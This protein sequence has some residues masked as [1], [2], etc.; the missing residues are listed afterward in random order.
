MPTLSM[1]TLHFPSTLS[2]PSNLPSLPSGLPSIPTEFPSL[3]S[4]LPSLP[5]MFPSLPSKLPSL[6]T[7]LPPWPSSLPSFAELQESLPSKIPS[8]SAVLESARSLPPKTIAVY[9]VGAFVAY[10]FWLA[11]YRLFLSPLAKFPGRKL[12]ALTGW[13]EFYYDVIQTGMYW[14]QV[15][16]MH[17]EYG[18]II[19]ISPWEIHINDPSAWEPLY[20]AKNDKYDFG[21]RAIG[22]PDS[23]VGTVAHG[24]HRRRRAALS[25]FFSRRGVER[26][27]HVIYSAFDAFAARLEDARAVRAE[28]VAR[29]GRGGQDTI[30]AVRQLSAEDEARAGV[31]DMGGLWHQLAVDIVTEYAF[32]RGYGLVANRERGDRW[33]EMLRVVLR[34]AKTLQH[35]PL[36]L[37]VKDAVA[38]L[39]PRW[40]RALFGD[41]LA[42]V[43]AFQDDMRA[44]IGAI[45]RGAPDAGDAIRYK[46]HPTIFHDLLRS[47]SI[48]P[49]EKRLER[50]WQDG[51]SVVIGGSETVATV[52]KHITFHLL[53]RPAAL[54]RLRREL[55]E[56]GFMTAAMRAAGERPRWQDLERCRYLRGV[57]ME[58]LRMSLP[59]VQRM[60]RVLPRQERVFVLP[61]RGRRRRPGRNGAGAAVTA[62]EKLVMKEWVVPRGTPVSMSPHLLH[63]DE[64]I[65][66]RPREFRPERWLDDFVADPVAAMTTGKERRLAKYIAAFG[67]GTRICVGMNLAYAE[68]HTLV[69]LLFGPNTPHEFNLKLY[70]TKVEDINFKHDFVV[71][72]PPLESKGCRVIV[73]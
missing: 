49:A 4:E 25:P 71:G 18:P 31:V 43:V 64:A 32:A 29:A 54:A 46:T 14:E 7:A 16:K 72:G 39:P 42:S 56:G 45:M 15:G 69:A 34:Q 33:V 67:Y 66:P 10:C 38:V 65:F 24:L 17:E 60:N 58:G 8:A 35:F 23:T 36:L 30:D 40:V 2:F 73:E 62:S 12:A 63:F 20:S 70:H 50:L 22:L 68:M 5:S 19:R 55:D 37:R 53:D 51:Q 59:A 3:P 11:V 48:P 13:Y 26:F 28:A 1:P 27:G 21:I 44:Q 57:V 41:G 6:P 52:F 47:E 9:A 61:E